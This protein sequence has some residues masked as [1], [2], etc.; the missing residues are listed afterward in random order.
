MNLLF[1]HQG[2]PGQYR[3]IVRALAKTGSHRIV[4]MG[5]D[6]PTEEL[7]QGVHYVRYGLKRGNAP[8][9]HPWIVESE[10]KVLRGEACATAAFNLREQ[11]FIPDVMCAH[12]GWGES[13]FLKDIWPES[14]LLSYQEFFYQPHGFDYDFDPELQGKPSWEQCS[15]LRMKNANLLLNLESSDWNV[16]PTSFQRSTFPASW[17]NRI[18][19]IHDG[20]DTN[21]AAPDTSCLSITL[22]D[23]TIVS[24]N[25][26]IVTFVNRHIEP[27][28]GCH[29][30]LRSIPYLQHLNPNARVV[31]VGHQSGVS[32][33]KAAPS[34]SWKDVFMKEIAPQV[35]LERVHFTGPLPYHK[36]LRLLKITSAHVYLTYPFVLSWSLLE[37]MSSEAP[38][39]GS[40]T[41]PVQ[42]VIDDGKNGLLVDF[43]SPNQIADAINELLTSHKLSSDLGAAA[44]K[45]VL[46]H[47]SLNICLPRQLALIDLVASRTLINF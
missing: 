8:G 13:L 30:F 16:T 17:Q 29:S 10:S 40:A 20:I 26:S 42:E 21:L 6:A 18:S 36:F 14:P 15:Y 25:D 2:F 27:Y 28:R 7:P 46:T 33:G 43:F 1:V 5:I 19:C 4:G 31:I 39:V 41:P 9:T 11:G 45:T 44:R 34:G 35:N 12:P 32:Y 3:H 47:Y 38:I 24:K 23:N 22:P 37:A